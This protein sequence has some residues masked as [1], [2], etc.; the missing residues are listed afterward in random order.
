MNGLLLDT[1]TGAR[2]PLLLDHCSQLSWRNSCGRCPTLWYSIAGK[3]HTS[4]ME[5]ELN[6]Q[7][8]THALFAVKG[9][10]D[11]QQTHA[12]SIITMLHKLSVQ[13]YT[14]CCTACILWVYLYS[15]VRLAGGLLRGRE[16]LHGAADAFQNARARRRSLV[17]QLQRLQ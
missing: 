15:D 10:Y 1:A 14:K 12:Y 16:G 7:Y 3:L 17:L 5:S 9:H 11:T 4:V 2:T 6:N 13:Y 8:N